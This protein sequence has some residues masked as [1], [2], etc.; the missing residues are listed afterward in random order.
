MTVLLMIM[1]MMTALLIYDFVVDDDIRTAV[2]RV[3]VI[4]KRKDGLL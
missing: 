4:M 2:K 3:N 1:T